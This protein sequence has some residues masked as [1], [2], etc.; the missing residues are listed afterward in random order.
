M[1]SDLLTWNHQST[2]RIR[3]LQEK[4]ESIHECVDQLHVNVEEKVENLVKQSQNEHR[5]KGDERKKQDEKR[6]IDAKSIFTI[7]AEQTK[8]DETELKSLLMKELQ[9]EKQDKELDLLKQGKW[10]HL[11][12]EGHF[13]G[14]QIQDRAILCE[15][16]EN[17]QKVMIYVRGSNCALMKKGAK[18]NNGRKQGHQ[19]SY[20]HRGQREQYGGPWFYVPGGNA[21]GGNPYF[22]GMRGFY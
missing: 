12:F 1:M 15:N 8:L 17:K 9:Q 11:M 16:E 3:E 22:P 7:V 13:E 10:N 5:P 2:N 19:R 4:L 14:D 18:S 21:P 6:A 20:P